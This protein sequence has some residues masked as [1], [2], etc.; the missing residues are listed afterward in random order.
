MLVLF[1]I[2]FL[3][4]VG[5]Y[6]YN[7]VRIRPVILLGEH[8]LAAKIARV[9][10]FTPQG[11]FSLIQLLVV[12]NMIVGLSSFNVNVLILVSLLQATVNV[13]QQSGEVKRIRTKV[14]SSRDFLN[15]RRGVS[16]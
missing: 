3:V 10:L 9:L 5:R 8:A 7:S 12:I 13:F 2:L 6:L 16:S 15:D 4:L 1:K 11:K 14:A